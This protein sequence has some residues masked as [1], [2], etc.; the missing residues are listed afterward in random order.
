MLK[1]LPADLAGW[2]IVFDLD[3]TLYYEADYVASARGEIID[4]ILARYP[5]VGLGAAEMAA[6]MDRHPFHGPGAFDAL[7][8]AL[9]PEVGAEA[10][11][12]WMRRVYRSH[13]PSIALRGEVADLLTT[14][15]GRG[16][17]LGVITDGRVETQ[18]LKISALGLGRYIDRELISVSEAIGAEKYKALPF[19]RMERLTPG[20][21]RRMYV[22]DNPAKDF[23]HPKAMGWDTVRV[24]HIPGGKAIFADRSV[25]YPETHRAAAVIDSVEQLLCLPVARI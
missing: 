20:A 24:D 7:H 15:R 2:S 19:E 21:R 16:A 3:D 22:G 17:T 11:V 12:L 6:I 18:S 4:R 13:R 25:S 1:P 9:P 14:L 10:T 8:A 23:I 5:S